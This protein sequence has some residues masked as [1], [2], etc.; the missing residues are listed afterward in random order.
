MHT[1]KIGGTWMSRFDELLDNI[2]IGNRQGDELYQ[3]IF[4]VSAYNGMT[5]LLLRNTKNRQAGRL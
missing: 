1:I 2:F 3:R 5:N 4:V